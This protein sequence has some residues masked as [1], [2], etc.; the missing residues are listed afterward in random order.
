MFSFC[1]VKVFTNI[2]TFVDNNPTEILFLIF[3]MNSGADQPVDL[4]ELY[5]LMTVVPGFTEKAYKHT[6]QTADWPTL[7]EL[8]E[9]DEVRN[10]HHDK[11]PRINIH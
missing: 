9:G 5:N 2:N 1:I 8:I 7:R 4:A 6:N 11:L 10:I 3:Q